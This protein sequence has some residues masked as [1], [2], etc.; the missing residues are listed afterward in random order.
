MPLDSKLNKR[1][2]VSF[3][4]LKIYFEQT[5]DISVCEAQIKI[6]RD[7]RFNSVRKWACLSN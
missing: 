1:H 2:K 5:N 6:L 3:C 4:D 7:P